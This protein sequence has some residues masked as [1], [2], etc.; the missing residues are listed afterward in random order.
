MWSLNAF[1]EKHV[2][3]I[4]KEVYSHYHTTAYMCIWAFSFAFL[5]TW[6]IFLMNCHVPLIRWIP[7]QPSSLG[8]P[9]RS[10]MIGS[11]WRNSTQSVRTKE[12]LIRRQ[13]AA[14]TLLHKAMRGIDLEFWKISAISGS[15]C[16]LSPWR[17]GSPPKWLTPVPQQG[18]PQSARVI[19]SQFCI[20]SS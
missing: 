17:A 4:E 19:H 5:V 11:V 16:N 8:T 6:V 18:C 12:P 2:S 9:V 14:I 1:L 15:Q 13:S 20:F 10:E 7:T 3:I